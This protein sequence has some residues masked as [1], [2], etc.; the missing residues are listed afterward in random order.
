M[1]HP[2]RVLMLFTDGVGIGRRDPSRNP[3]FSAELPALK[4]LLGG[5]LPSARS[6]RLQSGNVSCIPVNATLGVAGLPQSGTGQTALFTGLNAA[7]AIGKHFG[8]Y[9]YSSLIPVIRQENIFR[10]LLA[11]GRKV[12]YANAFPEQYFAYIRVHPNRMTVPSMSY[13]SNGLALAD[14]AAL[15]E[16]RALSA[17]ITNERWPSMGYPQIQPLTPREAGHRLARIAAENDFTLYEYF[18]TD[19]AGHTRSMEKAEEAL[20]RLDGLL[21]G[22]LGGSNPET[23]L[24]LITSDHGNIEDVSSKGH[25]KNRV[26]LI[27]WGMRHRDVT[28]NVT[29]LTHITP[30][31]L[32]LFR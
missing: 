6:A 32:R 3:F 16:G 26:P 24:L 31:I 29:D 18:L 23:L 14:S 4:R 22:I 2:P 12:C 27:A 25:T 1:N 28:R 10:R 13:A 5:A 17:D 19:L 7:R 11:L 21:M 20:E 9:P 30:N 15:K 8:P